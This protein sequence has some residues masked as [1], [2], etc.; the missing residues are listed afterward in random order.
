MYVLWYKVGSRGPAGVLEPHPAVQ[1][2]LTVTD[3]VSILIE[4]LIFSMGQ[5][6]PSVQNEMIDI[7]IVEFRKTTA[8]CADKK[9][10]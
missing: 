8:V 1:F 3:Y 2:V 5:T 9:L 4:F 10:N 7:V 6:I